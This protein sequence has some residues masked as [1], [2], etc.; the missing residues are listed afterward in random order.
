MPDIHK[1]INYLKGALLDPRTTWE[2]Y[3]N[4]NPDWK[5]TAKQLTIPLVVASAILTYLFSLVFSSYQPYGVMTGSFRFLIVSLIFTLI[6]YFIFSAVISYL[7]GYFKGQNNYDKALAAVTLAAVPAAA[8]SVLG[9]IPFIGPLL[10]IALSIYSL[11]LLYR[12]IP[13]FLQVPQENRVKHFISTI[14]VAFIVGLILSMVMQ[15]FYWGD[16]YRIENPG[17]DQAG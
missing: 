15:L 1:T 5:T 9:T 13:V 14:V 2:Q 12:N 6:G 17:V 4:E 10:S 3:N 7:A 8:G 16:N 11:V